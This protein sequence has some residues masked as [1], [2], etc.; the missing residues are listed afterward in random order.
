MHNRSVVVVDEEPTA[1]SVIA[2][3][4]EKDG[5]EPSTFAS[6]GAA[7][8]WIASVKELPCL[9]VVDLG[10]RGTRGL[11]F[12]RWLL[13]ASP[14]SRVVFTTTCS[15]PD[16]HDHG[17]TADEARILQKPFHAEDLR[18]TVEA[19]LLHAPA[20]AHARASEITRDDIGA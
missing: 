11:D 17:L 20:G 14:Q 6:T 13:E 1:Q 10:P 5:F 3:M 7:R 8:A 15:A 16:V 18:R 9:A 2:F 4:L 19:L 12:A